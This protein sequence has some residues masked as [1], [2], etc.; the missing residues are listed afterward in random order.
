MPDIAPLAHLFLE[1]ASE[2]MG[3]RLSGFTN[4][5]MDRLTAA[6]WPGN[7]RQLDNEIERAVALAAAETE[8][9]GPEMLSSDLRGPA[10]RSGGGDPVAAAITDWD[11]NRSVDRLKARM[12]VEAI[13]ATGSK[14]RA[15]ERLGI[16]RQSL[17][18]MMKRLEITDA[19]L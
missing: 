15:A 4:A 2:R 16:P 17:Q 13:R 18:K 5:A 10:G 8:L 3:R 1:R 7:V 6:P 14:T 12:I 9:V 11:L 19:D